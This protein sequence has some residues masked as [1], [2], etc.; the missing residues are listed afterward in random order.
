MLYAL[1]HIVNP[2]FG[3]SLLLSLE[4]NLSY[5]VNARNRTD[6]SFAFPSAFLRVQLNHDEKRKCQNVD[7]F[8]QCVLMV[9]FVSFFSAQAAV[10]AAPLNEVNG[11]ESKSNASGGVHESMNES[12]A[13]ISTHSNQ[14]SIVDTASIEDSISS[15]HRIEY[16]R[17]DSNQ[18][19][20]SSLNDPD[21]FFIPEYPPVSPKE[22]FSES[23]VHYFEDGNFWMEIPGLLDGDE[24]DDD[25][26]DY[27]GKEKNILKN[28]KMEKK[29]HL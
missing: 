7:F 24:E 26:L 15:T 9:F 4:L 20:T 19:S 28:C 12:V 8:I 6:Q 13:S 25:D 22:V 16:R 29:V 17:L 3:F 14:T 11:S 18:G 10:Q 1:L 2:I 21:Q 27:P 23:G 5:E